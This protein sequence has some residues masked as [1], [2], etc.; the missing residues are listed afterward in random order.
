MIERHTRHLMHLVDD[1]LDIARVTQ[2]K[3]SITRE[4][5]ELKTFIT[6]ALEAVGPFLQERQHQ[7]RVEL[8]EQPLWLDGDPVRLAQIV[9]NVLHNAGKY[10]ARGGA[11]VLKAEPLGD[12]VCISISDN[13]IGIAPEQCN[14][15]FDL[16]VQAEP[17]SDRAQDGLGIGLALV[18]TLTALHAGSIRATSLG[19]GC[20][21]VFEIRLPLSADAAA[22][23]VIEV[24]P[25]L[26]APV[27]LEADRGHILIV[28]DN[29]DSA[30]ALSQLLQLDGFQ[31]ATEADGPAAL[32]YVER[33]HPGVI[34]LDIG[35][36]GMSGYELAKKL[37]AL[38]A[39][40][41][42][43][44]IALTGYG[45]EKDKARAFQAGF[46]HHITKP[47]ELAQLRAIL[48]APR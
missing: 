6:T 36:P 4:R 15:I 29:S 38:P 47:A 23:P 45:Q 48:A 10:T 24:P 44:L 3:V 42:A 21:S 18:K 46:D 2:G 8:P 17:S 33:S 30:E 11:I 25:P 35:L 22:A 34:F 9:G 27:P 1:L 12:S 16:F 43:L 28:D 13:G 20:G 41:A 39:A 26:P 14:D 5:V 40:Q 19:K 32:R 31:V 7:L 37:R